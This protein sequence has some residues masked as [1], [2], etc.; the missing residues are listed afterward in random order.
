MI[1]LKF[2][3]VKIIA[4]NMMNRKKASVNKAG[5]EEL[6]KT[7]EKVVPLRQPA[8]ILPFAKQSEELTHD[9]G[10][11]E[12]EEGS[13]QIEKEVQQE[14]PVYEKPKKRKLKNE[15]KFLIVLAVFWMLTRIFS[16]EHI[17]AVKKWR[18]EEPVFPFG[19]ITSTMLVKNH[20]LPLVELKTKPETLKK[21]DARQRNAARPLACEMDRQADKRKAGK[22]TEQEKLGFGGRVYGWLKGIGTDDSIK[23]AKILQEGDRG[24]GE[25]FCAYVFDVKNGKYEGTYGFFAYDAKTL[26]ADRWISIETGYRTAMLK[27]VLASTVV[28]PG[29]IGQIDAF[30]PARSGVDQRY[31]MGWISNSDPGEE[32]RMSRGSVVDVVKGSLSGMKGIVKGTKG[33]LV[34]VSPVT[35]GNDIKFATKPENLRKLE[36][37][38]I[39]KLKARFRHAIYVEG[40]DGKELPGADRIGKFMLDE[41]VEI[42]GGVYVGLRGKIIG[43]TKDG[44]ILIH[45]ESAGK[46]GVAIEKEKLRLPSSSDAQA[47]KKITLPLEKP[48][49][50]FKADRRVAV[51]AEN[52]T[53]KQRAL[54]YVFGTKRGES[55]VMAEFT[56]KNNS[57]GRRRTLRIVARWENAGTIVEDALDIRVRARETK[58]VRFIT[59]QPREGFAKVS[60]EVREK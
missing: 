14:K 13:A 43:A 48:V 17:E 8:E 47:S 18:E 41:P 6:V 27:R 38:S 11:A 54:S 7:G 23:T 10:R 36:N 57:L 15:V 35:L 29:E 58:N 31:C 21:Y 22:T 9:S 50:E 25:P 28:R 49:L 52:F 19:K 3:D 51:E 60:V 1:R 56:A 34:L 20:R 30:T 24:P 26:K 40:D 42:S 12:K 32:H 37:P 39:N 45:P 53:V 59:L 55:G 4:G 33:G 44:E 2:Q 5:Q 16:R 46:K